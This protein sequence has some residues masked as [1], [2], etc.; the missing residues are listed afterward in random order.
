[1]KQL[2]LATLCFASVSAFAL[3]DWTVDFTCQ[4]PKWASGPTL[5]N[6]QFDGRIETECTFKPNA[7]GN[8]MQLD[9]ALNKEVLTTADKI[10]AGPTQSTHEGMTATYY[11]ASDKQDLQG[12]EATVRA[13]V[14]LATDGTSRY[15]SWTKSKDIQATGLAKNL[16]SVEAGFDIRSTA[17]GDYTV[18]FF[19][20]VVITKPGAVPAGIFKN[21]VV[22]G[23]EEE[24]TTQ[25]ETYITKF[26]ETL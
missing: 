15:V 24:A 19:T 23:M 1:M 17:K 25:P 7:G 2:W 20:T 3:T 21:K 11:D 9:T 18:K 26:V 13:D 16:K 6:G 5:A 12:M 4:A 10:H 8:F 14:Y 22:A